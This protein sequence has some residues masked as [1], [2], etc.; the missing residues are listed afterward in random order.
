MKTG[1]NLLGGE[2]LPSPDASCL[3]CSAHRKALVPPHLHSFLYE[4]QQHLYQRQ[5]HE[6]DASPSSPAAVVGQGTSEE[7]LAVMRASGMSE[8]DIARQVRALQ[9]LEQERQQE[10]QR[11]WQ[12]HQ[13]EQRRTAGRSDKEILD[14]ENYVVVEILAQDEFQALEEC[15]SGM[16]LFGCSVTVV[17]SGGV[18]FETPLCY[19]CDPTGRDTPVTVK[20]R[21]RQMLAQEQKNKGSRMRSGSFNRKAPPHVEY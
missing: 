12:E 11:Q 7:T 20:N 10:I 6:I 3:L 2:R 9:Q 4:G 1:D 8:Q 17:E 21:T 19:D 16:G 5:H 14:R 13:Q 18:H 15:W